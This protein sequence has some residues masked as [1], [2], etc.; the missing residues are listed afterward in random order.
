MRTF[1]T[2]ATRDENTTKP[3]Y[4]G[5]FSPRVLKRRAAYMHAHRIQADGRLRASDN[6]KKGIPLDEFVSSL[7]RHV[8][9]V[10]LLHQGYDGEATQDIEDALCAIMFNA[11]GYLHERLKDTPP[12]TTQW[13][14]SA[15]DPFFVA[16]DTKKGPTDAPVPDSCIPIFNR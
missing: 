4:A 2:G 11:E 9:D 12:Y 6:W 16:E 13:P 1:E 8:V 3:D 14:E 15:T 7:L 5:F 10:W